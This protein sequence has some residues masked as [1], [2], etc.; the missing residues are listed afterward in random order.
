M[1]KKGLL[2]GLG[3]FIGKTIVVCGSETI[4]K[5][6]DVFFTKYDLYDKMERF[7]EETTGTKSE[8]KTKDRVIGF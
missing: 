6:M 1:F 4:G 5:L 8:N 3:F 2:F 7:A